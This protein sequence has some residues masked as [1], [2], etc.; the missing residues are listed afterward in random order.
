M[1]KS[2]VL[3]CLSIFLISCWVKNNDINNNVDLNTEIWQKESN[4]NSENK[5]K[6]IDIEEKK[7]S[8]FKWLEFYSWKENTKW[9]FA[10]LSWTNRI[11]TCDEI[12]NAAV[13]WIEE[14]KKILEGYDTK[15]II[16]NNFNLD[17][18]SFVKPPKGIL[19]ILK[20]KGDIIEK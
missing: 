16:I 13:T 10:L 14:G 3:F 17:W 9:K 1:K 12:K 15:K 5:E 4:D 8:D 19:E 20:E 7:L 11:K 18:C 6:N 2:I